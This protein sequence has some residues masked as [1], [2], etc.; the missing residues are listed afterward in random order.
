[1]NDSFE[2][3]LNDENENYSFKNEISY[4]LFF[5]PWFLITIILSLLGSYLYLRYTPSVYLSNAQIQITKSDASSSFLTTEVTSLFGNRVNLDNDIS[6]ISSNHILKKVVQR[7]GLQTKV[8]KIG[9]VKSAIVFNDDI[10]FNF[11]FKDSISSQQLV[12]SISD[13]S[14]SVSVGS[15]NFTYNVNDKIDNDIFSLSIIDSLLQVENNFKITRIPLNSAILSLKKRIQATPVSKQGQ[16]IDLSISGTNKNRNDAVLNTLINI[17]VEDRIADQRQ[18]SDATIKFID[19][20]LIYLSNMIDSISRQTISYQLTNG[21][22]NV[23]LQTANALSNLVQENEAVY[24]LEVQLEISNSLLKQ[25]KSQQNFEIL[26]ANIGI[27]DVSV[28]QLLNSYNVLLMERNNL[29][30]STTETSPVIL[31]INQQL[32]KLRK[33]NIEGVNLY[34]K[35]LK[36]SL[37]NYQIINDKSNNFIAGLP[38]K[39]YKMRTMAREFKFA[40]DLLVFFIPTKRGSFY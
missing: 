2:K 7:L 8:T 16:V 6:V 28:N 40:E 17:L 27:V 15:K 9:R 26:P 34:I 12:L 35:N 21:V 14:I 29:L 25:L 23:E 18:L 22:Y 11:K 39:G 20:R 1:M 31:Q 30:I 38:E 24:N 10:P 32:N 33:A 13:G 5:W 37:S 36:V 19:G 4:Y 3:V